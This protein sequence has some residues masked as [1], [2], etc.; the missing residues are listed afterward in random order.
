MLLLGGH[1]PTIGVVNARKWHSL[2]GSTGG[3]Q[4]PGCSW[5]PIHCLGFVG[6]RPLWGGEIMSKA[7]NAPVLSRSGLRSPFASVRVW[8]R[9]A[10]SWRKYL[11]MFLCFERMRARCHGERK[12]DNYIILW[13][14][15]VRRVIEAPLADGCTCNPAVMRQ[16]WDHTPHTLSP[17]MYIIKATAC[18]KKKYIKKTAIPLCECTSH[19]QCWYHLSTQ[20]QLS[21]AK[22]QK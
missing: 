4:G 21:K 7:Q 10:E 22:S 12:G 2:K 6:P 5:P 15:G 3:S 13:I 9:G 1:Y 14:R 8:Q 17:I 18:G 16:C 11:W 19:H 20:T